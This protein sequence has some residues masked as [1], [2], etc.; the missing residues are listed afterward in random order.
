MVT[1]ANLLRDLNDIV[2]F[3][4]GNQDPID[5]SVNDIDTLPELIAYIESH[6]RDKKR[7]QE[8]IEQL[9]KLSRKVLDMK[10][11]LTQWLK[12]VDYLNKK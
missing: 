11:I 2:N 9:T 10:E 8:G 3:C 6:P 12:M 5:V 1:D 7:L 4:I